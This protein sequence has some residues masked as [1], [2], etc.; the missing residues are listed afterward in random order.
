[1]KICFV[2]IRSILQL[3]I[4]S[5]LWPF[6]IFHGYL[7]HFARFGMMYQEKSGNPVLKDS[8]AGQ[9]IN[10]NLLQISLKQSLQ[11]FFLFTSF[12]FREDAITVSDDAQPIKTG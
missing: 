9:S 4:W 10:F 1:M 2:I 3:C 11:H 12:V 5:I 8:A 7:V 6:G